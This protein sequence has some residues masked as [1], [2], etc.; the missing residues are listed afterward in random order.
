[1][2]IQPVG[3]CPDSAVPN[4]LSGSAYHALALAQLLLGS[5]LDALPA[6]PY[7]GRWTKTMMVTHGNDR[8]VTCQV[9]IWAIVKDITDL[10]RGPPQPLLGRS[11]KN[12]LGI[13]LTF[14][15]GNV[16]HGH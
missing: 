6:C 11:L 13:T 9:V 5:A 4:Q 1:M 12:F 3:T 10:P 2:C 7:S 8:A 14:R 16:F 15:S